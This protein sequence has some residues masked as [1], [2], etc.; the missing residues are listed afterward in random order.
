MST[1]RCVSLAVALAFTTVGRGVAQEE[2][3]PDYSRKPAAEWIKALRQEPRDVALAREAR[4]ALGPDGPYARTAIPLLI[5]A[6]ERGEE[7]FDPDDV[8]STLA[9]YGPPAVPSLMRA[10][11]RAESTV[12]AGAADALAAIRPRSTEAVPA[13]CEALKDRAA[14]VRMAAAYSLGEIRRPFDK[15]APALAAALKDDDDDVRRVAVEALGK[16]RRGAA[17]AVPE[18]IAA[19]KDKERFTRGHVAWAL[20]QIGPDA[21]AAVP[22]LIDALQDK[23]ASP[24]ERNS[25]A[26]AL[27]SI[28]PAAK[29]AVPALVAAL[30]E[31]GGRL[32]RAAAALGDIGP[33]AQAG[34]PEL[35]KLASDKHSPARD[36]AIIALGRIGPNARAAVPTLVEALDEN[37]VLSLSTQSFAARAL[38]G[39]GPD[40]RAA[41]PALIALARDLEE[42]SWIRE[43]AARAVIKIDPVLAAKEKMED[44]HLNVRLG[45]VPPVKLAPRPAATDE[46]KKRIKA[47]IARLAEIKDPDFG[48]SETLTGEAFAPLSDQ[49]HPAMMLLTD[50]NLKTS[51]AFRTL[52][53]VGPEA[54]PF[55]LAALDDKTPTRLKVV[56]TAFDDVVQGNPLNPIE[57]RALFREAR[58][59]D[60]EDEESGEGKYTVKVGDVC[61]VAIG[62][63]V[64]RP[65]SAVHYVPSAWVI[66]KS[67]VESKHLRDRVRA[68]W[69]SDD[70]ARTLLDSLLLDYAT[71]GLPNGKSYKTLHEANGWQTQAALRLLYYFPKETTPL[72]A[73]RLRSLDVQHYEDRESRTKRELKNGVFASDF[74]KA[75]A[76]SKAPGIPEALADI[77]RRTDDPEIKELLPSA[78]K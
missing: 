57:R 14:H 53:A 25:F 6:L 59:A 28:G 69:S 64:G 35:L 63:I 45:K 77:A 24:A 54:L 48:L 20:A 51:D 31:H 60:D 50:H 21:E 2:K 74:I 71:E 49:A 55:L 15:T 66:I 13:L 42:R 33:E 65:Y 68:V 62:Q 26:D 52:V 29:D 41:V 39:I 7:F 34:V 38:G 67:P 56:G 12:R 46:Q 43:T 32:D 47:L 72:I 1:R 78:R 18:L 75:V 76:W 22:V 8:V 73:G 36:S 16:L 30:R 58:Q 37:K 27:G 11:K 3:P 23:K 9:D 10:L 4:Q 19:L 17:P 5:D 61:F 40:A 70:P 44:A